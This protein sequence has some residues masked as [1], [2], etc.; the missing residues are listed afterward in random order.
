M[1]DNQAM[2]ILDLEQLVEL[3]EEELETIVG[4]F[5]PQP[6]PP[7]MPQ[8]SFYSYSLPVVDSQ[9]GSFLKISSY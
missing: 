3:S 4:G 6:D 5:N 8:T 9:I 2:Q 1:K 7:G